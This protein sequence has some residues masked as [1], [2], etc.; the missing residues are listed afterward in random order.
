LATSA[1][2]PSSATERLFREHGR[3]VAGLCRGLLRDADEAEDAAQQAFL[4]AHRAF[5]RGAEPK[6]PRAWLT[7][8]AR[9]ECLARIR[10]RMR[11]PLPFAD[12]GSGAPTGDPVVEA[13][14]RADMTAV[15]RAVRAL[16]PQQRQA[17]LL[18]E[19]G[20]LS[21]DELAVALGVSLPAVESLLFRARTRLR[22]ELKGVAAANGSQLP[23]LLTGR[24]AAKV[25]GVTMAA[26]LVGGSVVATEQSRHH[27]SAAAHHGHRPL[28]RRSVQ[29][30]PVPPEPAP[31]RARPTAFERRVEGPPARPTE[32]T[33]TT[34]VAP[35][36]GGEDRKAGDRRPVVETGAD[37][38]T[39]T[40]SSDG[41]D[42]EPPSDATT[43]T[44]TTTSTEPQGGGDA[45]TTSTDGVEGE[46]T[47]TTSGGG[48][49]S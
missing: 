21:Y 27:A 31:A 30:A 48:L 18:R 37:S 35:T 32:D 33:G 3:L 9:N 15:W 36:T 4:S 41:S 10:D 42:G 39:A 7:T 22:V 5:L 23:R 45:S 40:V 14:R 24:G 29:P 43:T 46:S 11:R 25:A 2:D 1:P 16:A 6:D 49:H 13:I 17:M 26:G 47:A 19:F 38:P 28:A 20:G 34:S 8:I 12:A 44:S